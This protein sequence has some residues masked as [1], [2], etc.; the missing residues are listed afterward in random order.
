MDHSNLKFVEQQFLPNGHD[1]KR[2]PKFNIK[3]RIEKI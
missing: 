2:D 1:S 3:D